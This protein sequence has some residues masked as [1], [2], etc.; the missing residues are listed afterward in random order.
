MRGIELHGGAERR[1]VE[2]GDEALKMTKT[3]SLCCVV[4]RC[5]AMRCRVSRC[6]ALRRVAAG[7]FWSALGYV[8]LVDLLCDA[9]RA[10]MLPPPSRVAAVHDASEP[11]C[12]LRAPQ[13]RA[14]EIA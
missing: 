7:N 2:R 14:D 12:A 5:D 8:N 13:Q 3:I 9:Q 1:V 11:S 6:A 10:L 4:M